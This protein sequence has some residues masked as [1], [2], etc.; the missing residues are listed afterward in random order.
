MAKRPDLAGRR[1]KDPAGPQVYL[2]DD[3]G[4]KRWIPDP[5]TYN[6]LFRDWNGI[7]E[8]ADT[9]TIDNGRNITEGAVLAK[10]QQPAV[11]LI[12]NGMKRW[13]TSPGVMDKFYFSWDKIQ[14]VPQVLLDFIPN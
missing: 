10:S 8:V 6:N 11:Y 9:N 14:V 7:E 12:D 4:T 13:V 5:P 3:D 2:I 1:I